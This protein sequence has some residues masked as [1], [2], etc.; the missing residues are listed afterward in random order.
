MR[1]VVEEHMGRW[2]GEEEAEDVIRLMNDGHDLDEQHSK[3]CIQMHLNGVYFDLLFTELQP[4]L[5]S[6][7]A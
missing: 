7:A 4:P 5:A 6:F 2:K 1:E 3:Q